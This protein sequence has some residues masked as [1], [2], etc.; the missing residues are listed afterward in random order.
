MEDI[1]GASQV[2]SWS[3]WAVEG[4]LLRVDGP[5]RWSLLR[6]LVKGGRREDAVVAF[7]SSVEDS[8]LLATFI[9]AKAGCPV[10]PGVG[11]FGNGPFGVTGNSLLPVRDLISR[12]FHNNPSDTQPR[13]KEK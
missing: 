6:K 7:H 11:S 2:S 8:R 13:S 3:C 9:S 12:S 4:G 1:A 10:F 5:S